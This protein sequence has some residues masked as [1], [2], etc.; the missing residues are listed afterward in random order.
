MS[1]KINEY[2]FGAELRF[3]SA[4]EGGR[5]SS[6]E[7]GFHPQLKIGELKTSCTVFISDP[8]IRSFTF[9]DLHSVK[10]QLM[11]NEEVEKFT[12]HSI[13]EIFT[14]GCLI[15]LYEGNKKIAEGRVVR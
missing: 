15:E 8:S 5:F 3:L 10:L 4:S 1:S 11:F 2:S 13:A 9:G 12:G 6:P 14:D 7:S